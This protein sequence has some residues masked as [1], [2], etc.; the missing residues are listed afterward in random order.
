MDHNSQWTPA[1]GPSISQYISQF[2]R[3]NKSPYRAIF[4]DHPVPTRF[5]SLEMPSSPATLH[6]L[7]LIA[8]SVRVPVICIGGVSVGRA[9]SAILPALSAA[10]EEDEDRAEEQ[11]DHRCQGSPHANGV[12][13][14]RTTAV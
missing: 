13:G 2:C 11:Q 9:R 10:S 6:L 5:N 1:A 8:S 12:I 3:P 14:M 7:C 4:L